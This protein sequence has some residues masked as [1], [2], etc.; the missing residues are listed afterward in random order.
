MSTLTRAGRRRLRQ[1]SP[2]AERATD[3]D[4]RFF[5]RRP[6]RRHRLRR[7]SHAEVEQMAIVA[8]G[9]A[10]PPG[11]GWFVVVRFVAPG[12]R[13][14][15]FVLG[16]LGLTGKE[17]PEDEAGRLWA[18]YAARNPHVAQLEHDMSA[19]VAGAGSRGGGA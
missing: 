1:L 9:A 7:A 5:E 6:D 12:A 18:L 2:E 15:G 16:P 4:R 14:R 10:A 8:G 19:A 17:L 13:L 3:G 11:A